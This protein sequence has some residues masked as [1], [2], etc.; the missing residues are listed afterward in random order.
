MLVPLMLLMVFCCRYASAAAA[1]NATTAAAI[2]ASTSTWTM[3]ILLLLLLTLRYCPAYLMSAPSSAALLDG[4]ASSVCVD[5]VRHACVGVRKPL[6]S[7]VWRQR[8]KHP[9]RYTEISLCGRYHQYKSLQS[10]LHLVIPPHVFHHRQLCSAS[11]SGP[12]V[13]VRLYCLQS[14]VTAT[15]ESSQN[16]AHSLRQFVQVHACITG[17]L[18][19]HV[20]SPAVLLHVVSCCL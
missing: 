16:S 2:A 13:L 15:E 6:T 4:K 11:W 18:H 9:G 5:Q 12:R 17:L 8:S 19:R 3:S 1:G 10:L 20:S 7:G 14:L